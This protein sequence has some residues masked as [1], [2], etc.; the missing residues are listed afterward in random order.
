[1]T[2]P[3]N[4]NFTLKYASG[5]KKILEKKLADIFVLISAINIIDNDVENLI[6]T[7]IQQLETEIVDYITYKNSLANIENDIKNFKSSVLKDLND[8]LIYTNLQLLN[9]KNELIATEKYKN[10]LEDFLNLIP[11]KAIEY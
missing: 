6:K 10:F 1:M 11:N 8:N 2:T 5:K 7:N 3:N 9:Y 4:I